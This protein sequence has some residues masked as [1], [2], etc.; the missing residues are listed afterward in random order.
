MNAVVVDK[1]VLVSV[2]SGTRSSLGQGPMKAIENGVD[3]IREWAA[4][5][6]GAMVMLRKGCPSFSFE[7]VA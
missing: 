4:E 6:G 7:V 1:V 5:L 2:D 3:D